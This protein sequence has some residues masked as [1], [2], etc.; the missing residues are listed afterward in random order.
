MSHNPI[1]ILAA[2]QNLVAVQGENET[3]I[4]EVGGPQGPPG[5]TGAEEAGFHYTRSGVAASSW[6]ITHNL[7]RKPS[8]TIILDTGEMVLSDVFYN[9]LN[10]VTIDFAEP[11]SGEAWLI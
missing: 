10:S 7:N 5:E 9:S 6:I 11:Q 8:V 1:V 3:V 2:P 4:V